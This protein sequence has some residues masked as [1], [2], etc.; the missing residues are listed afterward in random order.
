MKQREEDP[1]AMLEKEN[2]ISS[3]KRAYDGQT[4]KMRSSPRSI[5][6]V[7]YDAYLSYQYERDNFYRTLDRQVAVD[8]NENLV[9]ERHARSKTATSGQMRSTCRKVSTSKKRT[10]YGERMEPNIPT[11]IRTNTNDDLNSSVSSD[12]FN[13]HDLEDIKLLHDLEDAQYQ[14]EKVKQDCSV[15]QAEKT[16]MESILDHQNELIIALQNL[17]KRKEKELEEVN[18]YARNLQLVYE[19]ATG[20]DRAEDTVIGRMIKQQDE[21]RRQRQDREEG[22]AFRESHRGDNENEEGIREDEDK[23]DEDSVKLRPAYADLHAEI[24]DLFND[25]D[26]SDNSATQVLP[27]I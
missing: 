27:F 3:K 7:N 10:R 19:E 13:D 9:K 17:V 2:R 15:L 24:D 6:D 8:T 23:D 26:D 16:A 22:T 12:L 11:D 1:Y 20:D 25:D 4:S 14:L 18:N 21:E 5:D